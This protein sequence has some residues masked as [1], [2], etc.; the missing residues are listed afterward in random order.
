M[1]NKYECVFCRKEFHGYGTRKYC[2]RSCVAKANYSRL[3]FDW[4]DLSVEEK[5]LRL[6][7][8]F[9]EK[10]IKKEGCWDWKG[11]AASGG[12]VD[13][14]YN[15]KKLLAHRAS[16]IIYKGNIPNKLCVCHTCDNRRCT[17]PDHLFLGTL[18]ENNEDRDKKLRGI[19]GS[20]HHK[21][22][23]TETNVIEIRE[24]LKL[25]IPSKKIAN[26]FGVS[27]GAIWFIKHG[28]TWQHV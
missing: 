24:M 14:R 4:N 23:L 16:W 6:K 17:N 5:L 10:V 19:Q 1:K 27:D 28:K 7:K 26:D 8:S 21:S 22:K 12:Y 2:S 13:I 3:A 25:G 15:K 20:R 9:E 18:K 11:A